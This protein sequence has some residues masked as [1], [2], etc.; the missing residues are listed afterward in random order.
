MR[1]P[2]PQ[3]HG[4]VRGCLP[5]RGRRRDRSRRES[6]AVACPHPTHRR[7]HSDPLCTACWRSNGSVEARQAVRHTHTHRSRRRCARNASPAPRFE[8]TLRPG[9]G[10]REISPGTSKQIKMIREND[11]LCD[12]RI[13]GQ[14]CAAAFPKG[15]QETKPFI[16]NNCSDSI[17]VG[18]L[19]SVE[20][21]CTTL[22]PCASSV[23]L[24]CTTLSPWASS[25]EL[26]CTPLKVT[27]A[28]RNV[29]QQHAYGYG[30]SFKRIFLFANGKR[31]N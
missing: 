8:W 1:W 5:A 7:Q 3:T 19:S 15:I 16:H 28:P 26:G 29:Q 6:R 10:T 2:D 21:G 9:G 25:V 27:V 17:S 14:W 11:T 13:C 20:F 24:G 18:I 31:I 12:T 23:E 22:S 4:P 30:C